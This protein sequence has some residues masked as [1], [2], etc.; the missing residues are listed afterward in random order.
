MAT[1]LMVLG[2]DAGPGFA[3]SHGMSTLFIARNGEVRATGQ[4][5]A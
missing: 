1:A 4:F 5:S 3:Q 2:M